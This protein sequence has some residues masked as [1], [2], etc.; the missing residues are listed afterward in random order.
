MT[1]SSIGSITGLFVVGGPNS[2]T[3]A[4]EVVAIEVCSHLF[5]VGASRFVL[6]SP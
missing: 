6:G 5:L 3:E 2:R 1:C 4:A